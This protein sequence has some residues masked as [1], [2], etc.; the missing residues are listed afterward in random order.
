MGRSHYVR[1]F[2]G[3]QDSGLDVSGSYPRYQIKFGGART[4]VKRRQGGAVITP[5]KST[6]IGQR[7]KSIVS[8]THW[9]QLKAIATAASASEPSVKFM[10]HHVAYL[11]R[12]A[13]MTDVPTLDEL[14]SEL[15][16]GMAIAHLCDNHMCCKKSHMSQVTQSRNMSMQRC[17]GATLLVRDGVILQTVQCTHYHEEAGRMMTPSCA[18]LRVVDV[19]PVFAIAPD[20]ADRFNEAHAKYQEN[21]KN[22]ARGVDEDEDSDSDFV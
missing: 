16:R 20:F 1:G 15:G 7:L 6:G 3:R 17:V 2:E 22:A 12:K 10:S 18:K 4:G 13:S 14:H 9:E 21:M 8:P 11:A 19:G 5:T